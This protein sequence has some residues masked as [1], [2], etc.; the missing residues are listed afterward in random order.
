MT[1]T[2]SKHLPLRD[3]FEAVA[4]WSQAY[5]ELQHSRDVGRAFGHLVRILAEIADAPR[6]GVDRFDW[7]KGREAAVTEQLR[8]LAL[9]FAECQESRGTAAPTPGATTGD[10]SRRTRIFVYGTLKRG[11][12]RAAALAGQS[13][14]ATVTTA[15]RYRIFDCGGY[16]GL[17]EVLQ[18]VSIEGE[19]WEVD[20]A[21]LAA[22]DEIEGVALNLYA[23]RPVLLAAPRHEEHVESY[24][25]QRSV[26]GLRDCGTRW[27]GV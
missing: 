27:P 10:L 7:L 2:V 16:P 24:F 9:A 3:E 19:L 12:S 22:L 20:A 6:D 25:Y 21:C 14:L 4:D 17:V 15:A 26:L 11:Q 18:G 1:L 23:R 5:F 13:F 8:T